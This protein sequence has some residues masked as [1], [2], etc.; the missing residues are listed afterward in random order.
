MDKFHETN[1]RENREAECIEETRR[2]LLRELER[3]WEEG[4]YAL[5]DIDKLRLITIISGDMMMRI[6]NGGTITKK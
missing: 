1:K 6:Q 3:L 2:N 4:S 5:T